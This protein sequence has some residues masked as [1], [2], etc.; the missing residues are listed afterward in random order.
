MR[1][2]ARGYSE[3]TTLGW[4]DGQAEVRDRKSE[5]DCRSLLLRWAWSEGIGAVAEMRLRR[6][7]EG[8]LDDSRGGPS[9]V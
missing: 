4:M 8:C 5:A 3:L 7:S 2:M 6:L 1:C 9:T